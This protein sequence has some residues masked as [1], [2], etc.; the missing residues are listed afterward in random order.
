MKCDL[1]PFANSTAENRG[2]ERETLKTTLLEY[3]FSIQKIIK[4]SKLFFNAFYQRTA[5]YG[6]LLQAAREII[7]TRMVRNLMQSG[8]STR[9]VR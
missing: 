2:L 8:A 3:P 7:T 9:G 6:Q 5:E 1:M 4:F